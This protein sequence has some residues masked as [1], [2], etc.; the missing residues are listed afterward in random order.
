LVTTEFG[1][2]ALGGSPTPQAQP[3]QTAEEVAAVIVKAIDAPV[4]EV[5]TNPQHAALAVKYFQDVGAF[6]REFSR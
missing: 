5:Y 3:S 1:K 2:H 4:A 6:E